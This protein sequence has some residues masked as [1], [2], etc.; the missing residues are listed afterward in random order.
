MESWCPDGNSKKAFCLWTLQD[1]LLWLLQWSI[2][3]EVGHSKNQIA[4][5]YLQ[6]Y[7]SVYE[8]TSRSSTQITFLTDTYWNPIAIRRHMLEKNLK[9]KKLLQ[10]LHPSTGQTWT[11]EL[12]QEEPNMVNWKEEEFY[13][14]WLWHVTVDIS[15]LTGG[16]TE[17][18]KFFNKKTQ[19]FTTPF[20]F[21]P[22]LTLVS[23]PQGATF[24]QDYW[25]TWHQ[26]WLSWLLLKW[27][28]N[29]CLSPGFFCFSFG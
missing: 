24:P 26:T 20:W 18:M 2:A 16:H 4:Q 3:V 11:F 14:G 15:L 6:Y 13:W 21:L 19:T 22:K 25:K 10:R 1:S 7:Q 23:S 5:Y 17:L 28:D 27:W 9:N 29:L 12:F 8:N